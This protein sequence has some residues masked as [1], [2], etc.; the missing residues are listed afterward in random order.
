MGRD[1]SQRSS[2]KRNRKPA[3]SETR[4][5]LPGPVWAVIGLTAGLLIAAWIYI[6][7]PSIELPDDLDLVE[8]KETR[9]S[10]SE[11]GKETASLPPEPEASRFEF[12]EM[13]PNYE[14]VVP[15]D[16]PPGQTSSTNPDKPEQKRPPPKLDQPGS[17]LIQA[18]SFRTHADADRRRAAIA[19]LGITS[20]IEKVTI[21]ADAQTWYRVMIGPDANLNRV[22][23]TQAKLRGNGIDSLL[24]RVKG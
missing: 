9:S 11:S 13:L 4:P 6:A 16:P 17:Y 15:R 7:R 22:N 20:R 2:G 14:L 1:Y 5:G 24:I 12:Y 21:G 23:D 18:G 3:A 19:M 10:K 8:V